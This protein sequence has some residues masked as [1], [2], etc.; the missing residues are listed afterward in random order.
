VRVSER[1]NNAANIRQSNQVLPRAQ[2][3]EPQA[4]PQ[5]LAPCAR[6]HSTDRSRSVFLAAGATDGDYGQ[7]MFTVHAC[8]ARVRPI[9]AM[10]CA[11]CSECRG[12]SECHQRHKNIAVPM[13]GVELPS[14]NCGRND[15][16]QVVMKNS[17]P[18]PAA[19]TVDTRRS[20]DP[21]LL[22]SV[23]CNDLGC[24]ASDMATEAPSCP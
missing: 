3:Q 1:R 7:T 11:T 4:L 5:I 22:R 6:I 20:S 18:Q 24:T 8:C 15:C 16:P 14:M 10:T 2:P 17:R 13:D 9:H 21:E 19:S 23:Y 12:V